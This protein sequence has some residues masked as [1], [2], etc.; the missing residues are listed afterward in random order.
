MEL[1]KVAGGA[2]CRLGWEMWHSGVAAA[3]PGPV[4]GKKLYACLGIC[5]D[6]VEGRG[7]LGAV[8]G[9]R[10]SV[11]CEGDRVPLPDCEHSGYED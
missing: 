10:G 5:S 3:T 4:G 6:M 1:G 8:P 9:P 11:G 2:V 7:W